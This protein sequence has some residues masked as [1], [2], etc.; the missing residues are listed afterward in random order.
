M[1]SSR[2]SRTC[3]LL[4]YHFFSQLIVRFYDY[5]DGL[6]RIGRKVEVCIYSS[7]SSKAQYCSHSINGYSSHDHMYQSHSQPVV[8]S[9][10]R[11]NGDARQSRGSA[12]LQLRCAQTPLLCRGNKKLSTT[13]QTTTF[14]YE[15][16]CSVLPIFHTP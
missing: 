9:V 3:T 1:K 16:L 13:T 6:W 10:T 11:N 5:L 14:L 12:Q 15:H 8:S 4:G 2:Q 7:L